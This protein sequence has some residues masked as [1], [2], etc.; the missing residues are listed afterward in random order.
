[1]NKFHNEPW[2]GRR[3]MGVAALVAGLVVG[4]GS[5]Q[6]QP[7]L[8]SSC[9]TKPYSITS[10]G[11]YR[12]SADLTAAANK[13]CIDVNASSVVLDLHGHTITGNADVLGGGAS[14]VN[15]LSGNQFVVVEGADNFIGDFDV[16]IQDQGNYA[17]IEDINTVNNRTTGVWVNG[18]SKGV[19]YS[20][21]TNTDSYT[22]DAAGFPAF[23]PQMYGFR[24]TNSYSSGVGDGVLEANYIYGLWIQ[25]SNATRVWNLFSENNE[26]ETSI[27]LGCSSNGYNPLG[28]SCTGSKT[29]GSNVVYDD[30]TDNNDPLGLGAGASQFGIAIDKSERGDSIFQNSSHDNS[31]TAGGGGDINAAG[32]PTCK[33][34]LYFLNNQEPPG[35]GHASPSCVQNN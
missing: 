4:A 32:D 19:S 15:I 14:G 29:Y 27:Y 13:D 24:V 28:T 11:F 30:V 18:G 6:A 2:S 34:N 7:T 9:S 22:T 23:A 35:L 26:D 31:P 8:I 25:Q 1:M 5:A 21:I 3:W 17:T 16:G 20:Q 33:N 12:V 10:S